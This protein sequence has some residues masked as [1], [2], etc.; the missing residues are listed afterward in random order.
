[1]YDAVVVG[2]GIAGLTLAYRLLAAGRQVICLEADP[3][4]GGCVRTDRVNGLLCE[5]GAQNVLEKPGGPVYR[6][7]QD[8]GIGAEILYP[9][10]DGNFIAWGGR[11]YSMPS[12]LYRVLS[13]GGMVRA[14]S[15][16]LLAKAPGGSEESVGTWARRRFGREFAC[17]VID[18]VVSGVCAGDLE[19]LSLDAVFPEIGTLERNYRSLAAGAFKN[20][21]AKRHHYSFRNGMG[22]LTEALAQRLGRALHTGLK[23][24]A[25]AADGSGGYRINAE[26]QTGGPIVQ[27]RSGRVIIA[28]PAAAAAEMMSTL[29]PAF[30]TLLGS[31]ESA[32]VVTASMAF[33]PADF[34]PRPPRGYGLVRPRCEGSRLLG[35]LFPSSAFEG[36]APPDV[37]HLRVLAGGRRDPDA[38]GISDSELINRT[39]QELGRVLGLRP[40][41]KPSVIHVVRH[42]L[43]FP[44]YETGHLDRVHEIEGTLLRFPRVHLTGNS[45]YGLSVS[46][47]VERAEQLSA[48]ILERLAAA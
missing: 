13:F 37:I 17:R 22:A 10:D 16:L 41:A 43:G 44:Q 2:G 47:V 36:S 9:K 20:K 29:D 45:Y 21:P 30:G 40:D 28:T 31:I 23:A 6:L 11:L 32:P 42:R 25:I 39:Q 15:G 18:P 14:A 38:F 35:C 34:N 12:Q 19:R 7:A 1:M 8:L 33:S 24:I 27:F 5:R 3:A 46:K 26:D 48:R 4:A